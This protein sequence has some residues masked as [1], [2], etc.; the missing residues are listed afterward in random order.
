MNNTKSVFLDLMD[1]LIDLG[2][3][4]GI[5]LILALI[6]W[7]LDNHVESN[8]QAS[9]NQLVILEIN[10]EKFLTTEFMVKKGYNYFTGFNK[11]ECKNKV[12]FL[13][14]SAKISYERISRSEISSDIINCLD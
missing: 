1:F 10:E 11:F 3:S 8:S 4:C 5:A 12:F 6:C 2:L 14:N 9:K 7:Q 13:N